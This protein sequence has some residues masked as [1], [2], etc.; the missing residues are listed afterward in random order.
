MPK[1][2]YINRDRFHEVMTKCK[3]S[4][5]LDQEAINYFNTL[6]TNVARKY[7]YNSNVDSEDAK[8]K[9]MEDILGMGSK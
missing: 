9:A 8:S 7:Y 4:G 1:N 6:S 5:E 2:H 3:R